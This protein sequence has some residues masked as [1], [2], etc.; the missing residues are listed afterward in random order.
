[1]VISMEL[2]ILEFKH[3]FKQSKRT[4]LYLKDA[5]H[6]YAICTD[7]FKCQALQKLEP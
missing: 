5:G 4:Y 1:M 2:P 3:N 6:W 7:D